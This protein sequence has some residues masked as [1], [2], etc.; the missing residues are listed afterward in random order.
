MIDPNGD[1]DYY[2]SKGKYIGNDGVDNNLIG[3]VN[4][5]KMLREIKRNAKENNGLITIV[6][7]NSNANN[8]LLN[9]GSNFFGTF[10]IDRNV[11]KAA[12]NVLTKA[13]ESKETREFGQVL[14]TQEGGGA[15]TQS[16][17]IEGPIYDNSGQA[18]VD[19]VGEGNVSI[20]SHPIQEWWS[21]EIGTSSS[22]YHSFNALK[23]TEED[24]KGKGDLPAF[25]KYDMNIIVGKNG[26]P[27]AN[28]T[29]IKNE[30][31]ITTGYRREVVPS[32][33]L[34]INVF[35]SSGNKKTSISR[36]TATNIL[37]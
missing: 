3:I 24:S 9:N 15:L 17:I 2:N 34:F 36:E 11:L 1:T 20:H 21:G 18:G 19:L 23:P 14:Q 30:K 13:I 33:G 16:D 37:K 4:D 22:R 8:I 27:V 32:R 25:A 7:D 12:N 10:F 29:E 35:D 26:E 31:G 5:K 6:N 28:E